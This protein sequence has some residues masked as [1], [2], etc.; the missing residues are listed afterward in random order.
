MLLGEEMWIER[1]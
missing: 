1:D